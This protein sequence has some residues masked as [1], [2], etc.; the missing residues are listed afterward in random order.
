MP[1]VVLPA[2]KVPRLDTDEAITRVD[3][4]FYGVDHSGPSYE[5]RVFLDN[6]NADETTPPEPAHGYVGSFT[7]FGH[8]GCY[9][10]EGHCLPTD[11]ITDAFDRRAEHPLTPRTKTV[12]VTDGLMAIVRDQATESVTFTVVA[13]VAED[14][15]VAA[16]AESPLK[17][18]AAR[19]L[20]YADLPYDE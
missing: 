19:L 12:I 4:V 14:E 9:G 5:T 7:V 15:P 13:F 1:P 17:F 18:S 10:E 11:R 2:L 8:G 20:T 3:L 6:D 16:G